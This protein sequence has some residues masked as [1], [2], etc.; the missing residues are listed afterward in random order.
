MNAANREIEAITNNTYLVLHAYKEG[1]NQWLQK[2]HI[3]VAQLTCDE[4]KAKVVD[5][6]LSLGK[7]QGQAL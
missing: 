6:F 1:F 2:K 3:M 7:H 4:C 5:F